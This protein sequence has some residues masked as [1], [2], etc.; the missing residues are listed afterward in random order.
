MPEFFSRMSKSKED[1][2]LRDASNISWNRADKALPIGDFQKI[3]P[4]SKKVP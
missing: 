4:I 3:N 2:L 1:N